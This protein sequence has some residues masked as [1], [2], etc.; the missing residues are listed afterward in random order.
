MINLD[1]KNCFQS[2]SENI[3][4]WIYVKL[5]CV[6]KFQMRYDLRRVRSHDWD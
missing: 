4:V 5:F 2:L 3:I 1:L 6:F